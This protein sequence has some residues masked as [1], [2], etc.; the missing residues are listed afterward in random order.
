MRGPSDGEVW[1]E[2]NGAASSTRT[3]RSRLV[4]GAQG[5]R[6]P[7]AFGSAGRGS[8]DPGGGVESGGLVELVD[9][10]ERLDADSGRVDGE[11]TGVVR[12]ALE[13]LAERL[14]MALDPERRVA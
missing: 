12:Q 1:G 8:C 7:H 3:R 6:Q 13:R 10:L 14:E 11:C 5:R 9:C 4:V 2:A